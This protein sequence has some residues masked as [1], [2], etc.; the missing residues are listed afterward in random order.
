MLSETKSRLDGKTFLQI[1]F[2]FLLITQLCFGQWVQVGLT[3][4]SIKDI[5]VQNS[6]IF[7]VTSDSSVYRSLDGGINW[8]MIVDSNAVDVGISLSGKLFMVKDPIIFGNIPDLFSSLDNGDTWTRVDI[9]E[10]LIDSLQGWLKSITISPT[11]IVFCEIWITAGFGYQDA[12]AKST[13]DGLTWTTPGIGVVGGKL[14]DFR[15][16]LAITLGIHSSSGAYGHYIFLSSDFGNN[17]DFLGYPSYESQ[18]SQVLGLFSNG[19]V[20]IGGNEFEYP[21]TIYISMDMC[22]TWTTIASINTQVG[23][24]W[25]SG[26][27]EGMLIGTEDLGVFLFSDE[28][29]SL[30]SRSEGLT[31]LNVQALTLDNNGYVY[32][33]TGNGVWRRPL[34]EVTAVEENQI[35]IPSSYILSQNF[36]NPFNPSTSVQYAISSRQFISLKVYDVLGNEIETLVN[37]EKPA[38]NYEV[39]WFAEQLPSGVYFY[40]L[41]MGNYMETKKMLLIK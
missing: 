30:D 9:M 4:Q 11:G 34:S 32:A 3:G 40:Q 24:S 25:S 28:G 38:G 1:F 22:S 18:Y 29:D 36:P 27:E 12:L 2:C 13:D 37:E 14:F 41:K 17:W 16:Q 6:N 5:A 7:A 10:Q 8:P 33:G 21:K 23:L 26:S 35:P 19:N 20:I 31:D 39:T 15:D